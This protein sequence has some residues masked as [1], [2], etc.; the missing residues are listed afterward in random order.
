MNG[1]KPV[2]TLATNRT[3]QSNPRRLRRVGPGGGMRPVQFLAG[4]PEAGP[5]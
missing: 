5:I 2:C 1:P 4:P 3:N